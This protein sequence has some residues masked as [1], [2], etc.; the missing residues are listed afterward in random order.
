MPTP[1]PPPPGYQP[2]PAAFWGT[3][4]AGLLTVGLA[5][6]LFEWRVAPI[7]NGPPAAA[8]PVATALASWHTG[9]AA[10][11]KSVETAINGGQIAALPQVDA[12]LKAAFEPSATQ[13]T[14]ALATALKAV[15]NADGTWTDRA[16]A[17]AVFGRA[18][19]AC[20]GKP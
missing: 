15:T 1:G 12:A 20:G 18:S 11:Y 6:G 13:V 2:I 19:S 4:L 3:L 5:Y 8:D 9:E 17:A 14:A 7:L 16:A 10:A